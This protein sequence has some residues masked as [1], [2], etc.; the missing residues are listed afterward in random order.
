[1]KFGQFTENNV[2]N[3]FAEQSYPKSYVVEKLF[4][5]PFLKNQN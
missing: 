5:D 1:M 3:I 2:R 4:P